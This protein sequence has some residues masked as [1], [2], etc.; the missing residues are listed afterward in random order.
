MMKWRRTDR[1]NGITSTDLL[2]D[3]SN[4]L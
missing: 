1:K 2:S 3:L 4:A